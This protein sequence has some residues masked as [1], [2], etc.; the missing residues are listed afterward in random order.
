MARRCLRT[1]V[2]AMIIADAMGARAS[3]TLDPIQFLTTARV[4]A[5]RG[6]GLRSR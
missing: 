4:C 2:V 5:M 1:L 6:L 3:P